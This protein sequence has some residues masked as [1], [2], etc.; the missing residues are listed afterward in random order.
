MSLT[1]GSPESPASPAPAS[2]ANPVQPA[3]LPPARVPAW[4][5]V[6]HPA[7]VVGALGYFVDIYDLTLFSIVRVPSLKSMGFAG[8]E[9]VH[10]GIWLLNL[11]M[12]GMLLGG[13][14]F[15]ILGDR[16]GRVTVLFSSILLY[17]I[18]NI[19]NGFVA[20][21]EAYAVWRFIAGF[22]LA[23]ELGGS[24]TLVSEVLSKERR[25]YGTALVATVGVMGA[26][27]GGVV[28]EMVDWRVSYFV[29]GGLGLCLLALRVS[30]AESGMFNQ[31]KKHA[32][33]VARGQFFSLFTSWSRFGKYARCILIGLPSWFV[34]GV[35][36]TFSPEFAAA[37]GIRGEVRATV[38][39]SILYLG[40]TV[41]DLASGLLTQWL[42]S[43]KRVV[44]GFI[45]LTVAGVTAYFC[46]RGLEA[47]WFYT[48]IFFLGT[49]IGYWAVFVTI[50]AEQ[51][52]TN[53]RATV[54]TTVP[55][56]VRGAV[57]PITLAFRLCQQQFGLMTGAIIVG[58]VCLVIALWALSGLEET[59][60]KDLDYFEPV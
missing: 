45:L 59:H 24:I 36:V 29:G 9:L 20:S 32:K 10:H 60:G 26:V 2:S 35:L 39:V 12:I 42:G 16:V 4:R 7:V 28:A 48:I 52:G 57:V 18:A 47:R 43:R 58:V 6:L 21:V 55:N 33:G 34:V 25:A 37:L 19:A 22:G 15:G 5:E 11:Q 13:I 1:H 51:F 44:L 56:F 30:V 49:G 46:S 8:D 23:G 40:L 17:S 14:A 27:V 31:M 38:A 54:A 41:G 3:P 53:L 50:G